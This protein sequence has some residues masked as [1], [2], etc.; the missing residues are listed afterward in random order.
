MNAPYI[1]TK[2]AANY[3]RLRTEKA[4]K[5]RLRELGVRPFVFGP[6]RGR[7]N[8][9]KV[10]EIDAALE[11]RRGQPPKPNLRR[12]VNLMDRPVAD[13]VRELTGCARPQ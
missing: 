10:S 9:W 11:T 13:L 12:A 1:N 4:A 5:K 2:E 3:L 6:G 8:L 7:C